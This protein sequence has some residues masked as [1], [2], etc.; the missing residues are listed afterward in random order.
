[1]NPRLILDEILTCMT[2]IP[3]L[4]VP[5]DTGKTLFAPPGPMISLPEI[6]YGSDGAGI[7][8]ITD[9]QLTVFVG[10]TANPEVYRRAL[11]YASTDGDLSVWAAVRAYDWTTLDTAYVTRAEP[12]VDD[13]AG[14]SLL[15]YIFHIDITGS[16][17]S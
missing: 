6:T 8:R 14:R 7:D 15:G 13:P 10:P 4:N 2:G 9:L 3:G 16:R 11:A 17:Q 12:T 1:M 5:D